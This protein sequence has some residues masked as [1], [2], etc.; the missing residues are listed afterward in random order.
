MHIQLRTLLLG[1]V[2]MVG[3]GRMEAKV[4]K[5]SLSLVQPAYAE[6]VNENG[7]VSSYPTVSLPDGMEW[8]INQWNPTTGQ[9]RVDCNYGC[10]DSN[11]SISNKTPF[12]GAITRVELVYTS[13]TLDPAYVTFETKTGNFPV[14]HGDYKAKVAPNMLVW[15]V[16]WRGKNDK[17]H[18]SVESTDA[19]NTSTVIV[20]AINVY[21]NRSVRCDTDG[22]AVEEK[23]E[24]EEDDEEV[25]VPEPNK[26]EP[27]VD[28]WVG[29]PKPEPTTK[30]QPN[31]G[32]GKGWINQLINK[33]PNPEQPQ[34][35]QEPEDREVKIGDTWDLTQPQD[36]TKPVPP[37]TIN[38]CK[39]N[40]LE[41]LTEEEFMQIRAKK[42]PFGKECEKAARNWVK[43]IPDV[44]SSQPQACLDEL[45]QM[46]Y[47][48]YLQFV[49]GL[50][51]TMAVD[52]VN[53]GSM[54]EKDYDKKEE[55]FLRQ[56]VDQL[57]VLGP[58][59]VRLYNIKEPD[60]NG[61]MKEYC[62]KYIKLSVTAE[63]YPSLYKY[64]IY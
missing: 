30:Q 15:D 21:Y 43:H 12:K 22:P 41:P 56:T 36:P 14:F 11:F 3:M 64:L 49:H 54:T 33:Q 13:G 10:W 7:W 25:D 16:D 40:L 31:P 8:A 5:Y 42:L 23:D 2:V 58:E 4:V 18:I 37:G 32:K 51:E 55:Q 63:K 45:R 9:I 57:I 17:F 46:T 39:K 53:I 62:K 24:D 1:L 59:W 38:V 28:K 47:N 27:P 61:K 50:M 19:K 48:D 29:D 44:K 6:E 34:E 60:I 35:P 20:S 26:P 52:I